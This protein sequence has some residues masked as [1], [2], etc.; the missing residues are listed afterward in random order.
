MLH[1]MFAVPADA[2]DAFMGRYSR[3]LAPR[4]TE[5]VGV[6]P[7]ARVL[8]VGCGPGALTTV[9]AGVVGAES[10]A[11]ADP[12][13][14]FVAACAARVPGADVREAPAEALPWADG[15]FD[16]TLAQLVVPFMNDRAAAVAEMRRVTRGGGVVGAC[17]W[18]ATGGMEMLRVFWESALALDANAP[19]EETRL[20]LG[21]P[22]ELRALWESGALVDV[23]TAPLDLEAEYRDFD[24]FW[25]GF[26][27][28][29]GPAGSYCAALP[30]EPQ[31][32]L[33]DELRRRVGAPEGAFRLRARAW[34]VRGR[35]L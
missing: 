31:S 23:T 17:T 16:L 4:F 24:D 30:P 25:S 18:D 28:S 21:T 34:G 10:V 29:V 1:H 3:R 13:E 27:G 26:L 6:E 33:R 2:Y 9:L 5:F 35:V 19:G 32:A 20:R 11:A 7:A 12:S 8:D 15:T 22:D 14:S